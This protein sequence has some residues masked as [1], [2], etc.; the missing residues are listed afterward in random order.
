MSWAYPAA[1]DHNGIIRRFHLVLVELRSGV[2]WERDTTATTFLFD[3]LEE[4][5]DYLLSVAAETVALGPPSPA[6]NFTTL[7]DSESKTTA[8]CA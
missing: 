1:V 6:L 2:V 4:D 8:S 3:F 7:P 5:F